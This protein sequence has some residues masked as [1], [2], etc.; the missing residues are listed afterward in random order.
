MFPDMKTKPRAA[1]RPIERIDVSRIPLADSPLAQAVYL[2]RSEDGI[3]LKRAARQAGV[4]MTTLFRVET[5]AKPPS[6]AVLLKLAK[7]LKVEPGDLI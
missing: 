2:R 6:V 5:Q 4:S 3:S 7:W 1:G